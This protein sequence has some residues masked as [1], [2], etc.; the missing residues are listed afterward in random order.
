MKSLNV[1]RI[2]AIASGAAM[3]GAAFVGAA[4]NFD[5]TGVQSF[6]FFSAGEPNVKIVLGSKAKP[7]DV[8]VGANLAAVLGNLAYKTQAVQILNTDK[9]GTSATGGT[10]DDKEVG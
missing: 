10:L 9:L 7:E 6:P 5:T 2:A 3:L 1:K 4:V 8:V